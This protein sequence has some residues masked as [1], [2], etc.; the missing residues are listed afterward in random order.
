MPMVDET[1]R[2]RR[3]RGIFERPKGSRMWWVRYADEHGRLHREK[4]GPKGLALKVY[5]KRKT[6]VQERRFFP[7]RFRRREVTLAD[8]IDDYL[9]R[10][11]GRLRSYRDYIRNG[12]RWKTIFPGKTLRQILPGDIERWVAKR[13][14]EVAPASLNRELAFLKRLFNVAIADGNLETN[15]VRA[16]KLLKENN[17]RVRFLTDEEEDPLRREFSDDQWFDGGPRDEHRA[18]EIGAVRTPLGARGLQRRS[19]HDPAL[20]TRGDA[21]DPDE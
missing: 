13:I 14:P 12:A 3:K 9:A 7:D 21:A 8:A 4:V 20:Q 2:G 11:K 19:D 1:K 6:E 15:P 16:I 10:I 17:Q 18:E 5:Q